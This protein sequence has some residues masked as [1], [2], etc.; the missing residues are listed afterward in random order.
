[1]AETAVATKRLSLS[2]RV[3]TPRNRQPYTEEFEVPYRANMNVIS[4]L[5][6]I[7]RNPTKLDG[8]KRLRYAG[9][10]TVWKKYAALAP[11]SLT[12]SRV[13]HAAP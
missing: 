8:Q 12:A 9:S 3:R 1:M 5:M 7:Q 11:W 4:A 13:K 10:P 2:L 6:E